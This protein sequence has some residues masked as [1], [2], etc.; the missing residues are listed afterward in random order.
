MWLGYIIIVCLPGMI[1]VMNFPCLTPYGN[2]RCMSSP[3]IRP[4]AAP[5]LNTGIKLPDGIGMVDAIM[6]KTN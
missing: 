1:G 3:T 6:E 2:H 4:I 5:V